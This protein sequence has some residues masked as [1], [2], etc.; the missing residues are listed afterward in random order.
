MLE[1]LCR[2]F[3]ANSF[4]EGSVPADTSLPGFEQSREYLRSLVESPSKPGPEDLTYLNRVADNVTGR[5][6]FTTREG[7]IGLAL[8]VAR[9]GDQI[10]ILFGCRAPLLLRSVN[11]GNHKWWENAVFK[12]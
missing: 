3:C 11:H 6:F 8:R 12:D 10:C 1:A 9:A 5:S 4:A 2:T 7:H